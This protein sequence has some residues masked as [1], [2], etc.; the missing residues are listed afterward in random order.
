[1]KKA[2][3]IIFLL[4]I[5]I[6]FAQAPEKIYG[7]NKVLHSNEYYLEQ[8]ELLKKETEKDP[9]NANAWYNYYRADRNAYI[10]GEE[11]DS[12]NTKGVNRFSRLQ[13]IVDEMEKNVPQSAEFYFV[14]WLNANN[15]QKQQFCIEKAYELSPNWPE[16]M[17][18][19][20]YSYEIMGNDDLRDKFAKRYYDSGDFST[21]LLSY[22]GNL[23]NGLDDNAIILTEGDKDTD[24]IMLLQHGKGARK[25]VQLINL[26]LLMQKDYRD[27]IFKKLDIPAWDNDPYKN[28]ESYEFYRKNIILHIAKNRSNRPLYA[29]TSVSDPYTKG[30]ANP[31][32]Y[33]AGLAK[34][35]STEKP[36]RIALIE[37]SFAVYDLSFLLNY[38]PGDVSEEMVHRFN[39]NYLPALQELI[40]SYQKKNDPR[41]AKYMA[42]ADKLRADSPDK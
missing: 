31:Y 22:G 23:L 37:K 33:N 8:K 15:D 5:T 7:K 18:G 17:I 26:N 30:P 3:S 42:I 6:C 2:L 35:F 41:A 34:R 24:A 29:A 27:R 19:L 38:P 28:D 21:G 4:Q 16:P 40:A 12:L 10:V 11:T 13:K 32:L 9:E 36:D 20:M 1:M 39:M 14:K 25:D